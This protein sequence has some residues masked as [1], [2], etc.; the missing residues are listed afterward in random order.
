MDLQDKL[1]V[2]YMFITHDLSVVKHISDEI[3]VMYLGQCV[4]KASSDELFQHPTHPYTK[5]LLSAIPN[6]YYVAGRE[7]KPLIKGE[8]VSP[9]DPEPGCRFAKRCPFA[10]AACTGQD[11]PLKEISPGHAVS[12]VLVEGES[13]V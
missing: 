5:A 7:R 1:G 10:T 8:I 12:C 6:P 2:T 9:I 3:M 4:E 13:H 11:I